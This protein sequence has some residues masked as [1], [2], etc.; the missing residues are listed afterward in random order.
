MFSRILVGF[1]GSAPARQAVHVAT[2]IGA[3]FHS[4]L[5]LAFVKPAG[6]A[7]TDAVLEGL[8]P[9]ADGGKA[10]SAVVDEVRMRA[11]AEGAASV[12]SVILEGDVVETLLDWIAHHHPDL[13]I[14]GSRGLSRGRRLLLGSVSSGMVNRAPCPVMVV[15]VQREH[16]G[17]SES[18]GLSG[19][20][21]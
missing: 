4:V 17:H 11:V 9:L 7:P 1:D 2:E 20:S 10:F 19:P 13:V 6:T 16:R 15:R 3:R 21:R 5:T 14:V 8:V 18:G 12:E